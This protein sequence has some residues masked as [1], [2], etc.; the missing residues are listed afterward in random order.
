MNIEEF[1]ALSIEKQ[2]KYINENLEFNSLNKICNS[3][4][5]SESTVRDRFKRNNYKRVGKKF[6]I[7]ETTDNTINTSTKVTPIKTISKKPTKRAEKKDINLDSIKLLEE[8]LKD[9]E[10]QIKATN[11]R[12]DNINTTKTTITTDLRNIR[13]F[14]GE[15][16][17]RSFRVNEDVQKRFKSYCKANSEHKVSDILSTILDEYLKSQDY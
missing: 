2:I 11:K 16:V 13:A 9:L 5:I 1:N 3:I 17:V 12:I 10:S 6:I 15:E 8:K 7:S 4:G 14:D